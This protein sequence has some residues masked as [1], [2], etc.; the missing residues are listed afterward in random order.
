MRQDVTA[1]EIKPA[2]GA[3]PAG[4]AVQLNLF[5]VL[6]G[7]RTGLVPANMATWAS[8]NAAVA[9]VSRQGRLT[10][11]APGA[12]SITASYAGQTAHADFTVA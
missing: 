11:R 5:S 7:G 9:E 4:T 3:L 6:A 12:V 1:L 2:G 10:L 8:S